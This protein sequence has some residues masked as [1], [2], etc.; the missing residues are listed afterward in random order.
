MGRSPNRG[1]TA[2][3]ALAL[4][5]AGCRGEAEAPAPDPRPRVFTLA[6]PTTWLAEA[7]GGE[8]VRVVD[9]RPDHDN[10]REWAPSPEIIFT[11]QEDAPVV[12]VGGGLEAWYR[13]E[14]FSPFSVFRLVEPLGPAAIERPGGGPSP[15]VW[16]EPE[17]LDLA[18]AGLADHLAASFPSKTAEFRA[19]RAEL[20]KTLASLEAEL[21]PALAALPE[22]FASRLG[23]AYAARAF[24]WDME[25][26]GVDPAKPPDAA[27][28]ERWGTR[29]EAHP[30]KLILFPEPPARPVAAALR[31]VGLEPV[32]FPFL[33]HRR[34][35]DVEA[36]RDLLDLYRASAARLV[37]A[38]TETPP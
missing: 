2:T 23:Y 16:L 21:R 19:R 35:E 24:G 22:L 18:A 29:R 12:L 32:V 17:A 8:A 14:D 28:L 11:I 33:T 15:H 30:A 27:E 26:L 37:A 9:V 7:I 5:L 31:E 4:A 38:A 10:P 3:V 25:V 1:W 20:S 34:P 36:G 6:Y 13:P